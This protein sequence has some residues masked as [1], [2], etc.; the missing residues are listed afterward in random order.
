VGM[1]KTIA[2]GL[3]L[4]YRPTAEF[5][6]S[7]T[8]RQTAADLFVRFLLPWSAASALLAAVSEGMSR[9]VRSLVLSL[10]LTVIMAGALMVVARML[11]SRSTFDVTLRIASYTAP[12]NVAAS[13]LMLALAKLAPMLWIA[14]AVYSLYVTWCGCAISLPNG[15]SIALRSTAGATLAAAIAGVLLV[16]LSGGP[17]AGLSPDTIAREHTQFREM[18][19]DAHMR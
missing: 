7:L 16:S 13:L 10:A 18:M 12:V 6:A 8:E 3:G 1:Q 14:A 17:D 19:H 2:R 4:L 15:R 11:G 5:T 9:G